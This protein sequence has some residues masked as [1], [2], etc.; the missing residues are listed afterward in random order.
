[1]ELG[2]SVL[3]RRERLERIASAE[4]DRR[5]GR[6]GW[7]IAAL[8]EGVEWPARIVL[9]LAK[10][11]ADEGDET[12]S[13]LVRSLDDWAAENGLDPLD[14]PV[15]AEA[16]MEVAEPEPEVGDLDSPI[17]HEEFERAFEQAEAQ[18]DEMH[19]VNRVAERVLMD[20]PVG[21]AELVGDELLPMDHGLG[22]LGEG[23]PS[24]GVVLA[25]L[26]RWLVNLEDSRVGR[27]L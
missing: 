10:L 7:A 18:T 14:V 12:R 15:E 23:N 13:V 17:G 1:V 11:P 20:E 26:E 24:S 21:L 22:E 16:E 25:T 19:D 9:A 4:R 5:A 27:A 6:I 2:V 8:G 3:T